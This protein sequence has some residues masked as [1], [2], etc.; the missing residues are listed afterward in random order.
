MKLPKTKTGLFIVMRYLMSSDDG[1]P[2][3]IFVTNAAA[4]DYA[5]KCEQEFEDKNIKAFTFR[6]VYTMFYNE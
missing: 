6:V 5:G 2:I 3:G 4:D 1:I